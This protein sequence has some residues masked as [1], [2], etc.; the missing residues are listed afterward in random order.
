MHSFVQSKSSH[1]V[2]SIHFSAVQL[3]FMWAKQFC[4][5]QF[6]DSFMP[7][8][9]LFLR[10]TCCASPAGPGDAKSIPKDAPSW[11]SDGQEQHEFPRRCLVAAAHG[12]PTCLEQAQQGAGAAAGWRRSSRC[13][14]V[15]TG[16]LVSWMVD[17]MI[18]WLV[19]WLIGWLVDWL[20]GWLVDWLVLIGWLDW[21][22]V[23]WLVDWLIA[24]LLDWLIGWLL[25]W[26]MGGCVVG[27]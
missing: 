14:W 12:G 10:N 5:I 8:N 19:D 25:D 27:F 9:S 6:H 7:R 13:V 1:F 4:S 20:N 17:C 16:L 3:H 22:L 2:R 15:V 24:W 23:G 26:L 11:G 21:W 18:A